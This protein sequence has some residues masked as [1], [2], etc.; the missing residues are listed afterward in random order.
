MINNGQQK[1]ASSLPR[2]RIDLR[3]IHRLD[4]ANGYRLDVMDDVGFNDV[5]T[6]I[7]FVP[8]L[9]PV[10][11][12]DIHRVL[13]LSDASIVMGENG[14]EADAFFLDQ[15]RQIS[16]TG[17]AVLVFLGDYLIRSKERAADLPMTTPVPAAVYLLGQLT[18]I[19]SRRQVVV[20]HEDGPYFKCPTNYYAA[21]YIALDPDGRW[22]DLLSAHLRSLGVRINEN[23][24]IDSFFGTMRT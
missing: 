13:V 14:Y 17:C 5:R 7:F 10:I 23:I 9:N 16:R 20:L 19:L 15:V 21:S 22:K 6:K 4:R 3:D 8:S 18:A 11:N 24:S 1:I 2:I 12:K